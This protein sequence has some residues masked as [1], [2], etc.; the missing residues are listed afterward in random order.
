MIPG[1]R[2]SCKHKRLLYLCTRSSNDTS[3]KKY[4]K[5][6]CKILANVIK[7]AKKYIYNN[8]IN[9]SANK[10]KTTW[11]IIKK[12]TNRHKRLKTVTD[13]HNSPEAF[14]NYFLIISEN[15]IKNIR[16]NDTYDSPNYYITNKPH[17]A[18]SNIN[19]KNTST[20]ETES[21][22]RSLKAK[23]SYGYDEVTTKI[24]KISAPFISSPLTYIF[25]KPMLSGIFPS[26]L[27]YA[28]IKPIF[29]NGDKK[30]IA[31]YRPISLL[32]SFSK[33]LEKIIYSRLMN[34]LETNNILAPEQFG[35]RPSSSTDSALF[36]F[37]SCFK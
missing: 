30:N 29:K 26:R 19:F 24:L 4:Y 35:F 18:F 36:N 22:I 15:I 31:N 1:I 12:E 7:E 10:I 21:I 8:Q 2:T 20:K 16:S 34:H 5:Q 6:Y 11:N 28:I 3:V 14:N 37:K 33:I 27:K 32:P 9:K 23:E 13:Y 25:N 17:R